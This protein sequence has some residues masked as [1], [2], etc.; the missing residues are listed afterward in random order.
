MRLSEL[1]QADEVEETEG[2]LNRP[3]AG[4]A[5]DSRQVK[6]DF[7]FFAVP[8]ARTDGHEFIA[9]ASRQGAGAVVV[10][11]K[12]AERNDSAWIRVRNVRRAMGTWAARF[13][14]YPSRRVALV[15]VTGTNGKT[16]VTY[17]LEAIFRA[18]GMAT[19][20]VGTV[21]YR[22]QDRSLPAP[23][24]TPESID[25]QSLL[26]EMA[27][28]GVDSVA[29]E[30]SSHALELERVRGIDFDAAIFT[31]LTRDHLDFHVDMERYFLSKS[32]FFTDYLPSSAKKKKSA[33]I[34]GG[35]PKGR[36]LL[37]KV[38]AL[39]L[40]TVSYGHGR[41]WDVHPVEV[42]GDLDGLRG[43]IQLGPRAVEFTS[44]LIGS[45]NL[46]N[47][48]A[49]AAAAFSLGVDPEA[50]A[51]G[52]ARLATVPGRLEKIENRCG[53]CVLVDYAHTPDALE[54]AL[55]LLKPLAKGKLIAVFGCGG[56]RDRGKRPLMGEAAARLSD[57]AV[58]TSD[59]PRTEDPVKILEEVEA[60]A[61][62]AG[63]KK[64]SDFNPKSKIANPKSDRGYFVE[65]D[66]RTAIRLSLELARPGDLVLIAGKG[67]ED[68]QILGAK[69]IHFDDREVAREELQKLSS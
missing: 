38:K 33:V 34:H 36:E 53:F 44:P 16:T 8:G 9:A 43:K 54:R 32:K 27:G 65:P 61:K 66:R 57:V 42:A 22:Y 4:L 24:T 15:G 17:L 62:K 51:R 13:H 5:Y 37:G 6:K 58:L 48:L 28:A 69:K 21:N 56:D 63:T 2:N 35:D 31:N 11:R 49:A 52:L 29:M 41:E 47:I 45:A 25:L 59:N 40:Q 18:A 10:E 50:I 7:V 39:G 64:F 19:G 26:A 68:Y 3:V 12:P 55:R 14:G 46:E 1:V 23:H 30:V 60:G 20:V 67:H